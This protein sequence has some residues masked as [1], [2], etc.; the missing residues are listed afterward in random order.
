[1]RRLMLLL[2]LVVTI[3]AVSSAVPA[4][5]S[6]GGGSVTGAGMLGQS[7]D[8][9]VLV[10]AV[11]STT[12]AAGGFIIA[13][14]DGTLVSGRATCLFVAGNTAYLTGR[15]TWSGG[16]RSQAENWLF[17]RYVVIGI[18]DSGWLRTAG[19]DK[20]NFSSGFSANPGC[21]PNGAATPVFPIVWGNYVVSGDS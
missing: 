20:L 14:P 6:S 21:G 19:P 13:Y 17:G 10:S 3:G 11:Q 7:G 1:M 5:A 15:I 12:A 18:Q 2:I 4:S 9:T 16:P 8:P